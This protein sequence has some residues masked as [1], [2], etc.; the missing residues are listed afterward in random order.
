MNPQALVSFRGSLLTNNRKEGDMYDPYILLLLKTYIL[1][2]F[3][4]IE[5]LLKKGA[6]FQ[7]HAGDKCL[8]YIVYV[9]N[10]SPFY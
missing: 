10:K 5:K 6:L 8:I 9:C 3:Y 2:Q 4:N 7:K 1:Q